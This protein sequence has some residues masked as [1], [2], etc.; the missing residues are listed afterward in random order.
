M[1]V[2][3]VGLG[4]QGRKR[5]KL[6]GEYYV[7]SVDPRVKDATYANISEAP[8][9]S[10]DVVFLCVPDNQKIN[11]IEYC[12]LHRKHVL[13]EKPLIFRNS[14]EM[15]SLQTRAN[16]AGVFVYTAYNHRFE[17]HF[18]TMK[19][20]LESG[21]LGELFSIRMFYGNGTSQLVKAS[22]WRDQ[23]LGVISDLAPHLLDTLEFW[24]GVHKLEDL[25]LRYHN[26]ETRAPDHAVV[27][28]NIGRVSVEL[29]MSLCMWRNSFFCDVIGARGSAHISS[30]C[31]WGPS[32]LT[33]RRRTLPS[34]KPS[35][36]FLKLEMPDPT[37]NLEHEN[38]FR[39]IQSRAQTN[40][41][42]DVW[43][44]ETLHELRGQ[45]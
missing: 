34:G 15:L 21:E 30:L 18:K 44:S 11:L 24:L 13:V 4:V 31:K 20:I 33:T 5:I 14:T 37:W 25:Y 40:L 22:P 39:Q 32:V 36:E 1:K 35:E 2:L 16:S 42:K 12:I 7:G 10:F 6:I 17:P 27:H 28:A 9:E 3:V 38:F 19:D 45:L 23:G 43:I 41:A 26:F 29:E 8:I